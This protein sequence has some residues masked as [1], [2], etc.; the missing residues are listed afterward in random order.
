VTI[1]IT[2]TTDSLICIL[3]TTVCAFTFT[4]APS[5][6]V[7]VATFEQNEATRTIS[8]L[9]VGNPNTY[10]YNKWQRKSKYGV[11]IRELD[12]G[13]NGVLTLPSIPVEDR[14]QESGEYVCT[15]C[16]DIVGRDGKVEQTGSGYF[17]INGM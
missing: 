9:P 13:Q 17:I 6:S 7:H 4:D 12:G 1:I 3:I 14:Y 2:N 5:I 8:C 15:A 16:N 10:T 11:L